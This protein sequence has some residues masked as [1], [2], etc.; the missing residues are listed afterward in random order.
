MWAHFCAPP[1]RWNHAAHHE[2]PSQRRPAAGGFLMRVVSWNLWWRHGPWQQRRR[3]IAETLAQLRPDVCGLQE[4]WG[5]DGANLAAEL[6]QRLQMHWC[7]APL[8]L[9][10]HRRD[11]REPSLAIGNAILSR[12]PILSQDRR[13]LPVTE[14]E[15]QRV[16]LHARIEA[17][18][19]DLPFFTTHLTHR[20]DA[21]GERVEQV[22]QV[23]RF[24]ADHSADTAYPPVLTGDLNAEP[25]SDEVRLLCGTLT[26]P[27]V[28]GLV[29]L[30][31]WRYA[32]PGEPGHT[33]S[34]RNP[35]QDGHAVVEA[36]IDYILAGLPRG[37]RGRITSAGVA[38]DTAVDGVFGSD[39]FAVVADLDD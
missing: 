19:G 35:Y 9:Q 17:P 32:P 10:P 38:G 15:Q 28:P 39:H 8:P 22:R 3:P 16:V 5:T 21:S 37:G 6:A 24:V 7:W 20:I 27:S 18:G 26:A 30:D 31:A 11:D 12:W 33:W 29:F 1:V 2:N 34:R 36:R 4:V 23:A 14:P 13:P 25:D